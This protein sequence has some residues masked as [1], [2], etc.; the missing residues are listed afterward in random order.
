[1]VA[2]LAPDLKHT[3]TPPS[4]S[5]QLSSEAETPVTTAQSERLAAGQGKLQEVDLGPD[6]AARADKAWQKLQSPEDQVPGKPPKEKHGN[7]RRRPKRRNSEDIR[8]DA[9]VEAVLR[10]AKRM[11][12]F[13]KPSIETADIS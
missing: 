10:E 12:L 11:C 13:L 3:F 8:R 4:S 6:A 5:K 7:A 9:M 2:A 1:M